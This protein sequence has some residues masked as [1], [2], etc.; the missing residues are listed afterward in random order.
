MNPETTKL[1]A[2]DTQ[3]T[4]HLITEVEITESGGLSLTFGDLHTLEE[5]QDYEERLR[6]QGLC[7]EDVA[8]Y[9]E[10][11][12]HPEK[13]GM[14]LWADNPLGLPAPKVGDTIYLFGRGLGSTV[15]GV[16]TDEHI[17]YYRTA[18]EDVEHGRKQVQE[19]R[20]QKK[21]DFEDN[22]VK[23]MEDI[24]KLPRVFRERFQWFMRNPDWCWDFGPYELHVCK[25][26]CEIMGHVLNELGED[27]ELNAKNELIQ[28]TKDLPWEEQLAL[29]PSIE[30]ASGNSAGMAF[31]LAALYFYDPELI[32]KAHGALCPM[33][34]CKSYGCWAS[35]VAQD[36]EEEA[37][38]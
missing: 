16:A 12:R 10:H 20:D 32:P 2:A 5:I 25:T 29:L 28:K 11:M 3:H 17:Y 24:A 31:R 35:V 26:A 8:R 14:G 4:P 19:M 6:V 21:K 23:F 9:T 37:S 1:L 38:A 18:E 27:S 33:V 36:G 34:G 15:R 7:E 13:G 22:I 30:G